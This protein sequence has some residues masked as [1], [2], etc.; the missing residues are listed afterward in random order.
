MKCAQFNIMGTG[1]RKS[2]VGMLSVILSAGLAI[3]SAVAAPA[4][5]SKWMAV[6]AAEKPSTQVYALKLRSKT[7]TTQALEADLAQASPGV[8]LRWRSKL[9]PDI[10]VVE[11]P[12][13]LD[14]ALHQLSSVQ[15]VQI[16]QQ[17]KRLTGIAHVANSLPRVASA[18]K[19]AEIPLSADPQAGK[20]IKVGIL[21]TGID[22]THAAL[23]GAGTAAAYA[24]ALEKIIREKNVDIVHARSR[25]PA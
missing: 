9:W 18:V 23:G 20:G 22:Y 15:S 2:N 11:G 5:R 12:A 10:A 16:Q 21:S 1:M 4:D 17:T 24:D 19:A 13:D 7:Q 8:K 6:G 14:S 3:A 25:A